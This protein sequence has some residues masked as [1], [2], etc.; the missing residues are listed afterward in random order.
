MSEQQNAA[1]VHRLYEELNKD[2]LD[3][4]EEVIAENFVAHGETMGLDPNSKDRREAMKKGIKWAKQIFPD[5]I[6]TINETI[7]SGDRVVCRLTW[8][9]TQKDA[10]MGVQPSGEAITWTAIAINRIENGQIA[11][12]WFNSDELGM[13][14]QMG[15]IPKMGP[16]PA[17]EVSEEAEAAKALAQRYID[18]VN[19]KEE[20][21]LRATFADDF[22]DK[23]AVQMSGLA[24]GVEGLLQAHRMLDTAFPD[25]HFQ[26]EDA[27]VEGDQLAIRIT[28]SGT[29]R[30]ELFG[31]PATNKRI[32]WSGHRI[33]TIR[34]GRFTEGTNELDQVGIMT[35]LGVMPPMVMPGAPADPAADKAAVARLY[36]GISAG[37][38][39]I[40][41]EIMDPLAVIHG[42]S[43]APLTRG[44][45]AYK[46]TFA[47]IRAAFPDLKVTIE[48]LVAEDDRVVS[49]LR[50]TGTHTETFMGFIQPT[51]K[52]MSWGEIVT[53]RFEN[54]KIVERWY[55]TDVLG[56]FRQLGLVPE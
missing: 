41:D 40:I 29:Q 37:N 18:G 19:N 21:E 56:I 31:I 26:I 23:N 11:E 53:D 30:G 25:I 9:G 4:V 7:A 44:S 12:R 54:G 13:M 43:M 32:S 49:R 1:I 15:L 34:D 6:V 8:K 42:D 28:A 5:L 50:W 22:L 35:Q 16:P 48:N 55:N 17:K 51:N 2:N 27:V 47:P 46:A 24:E 10:F 20:S 33:L 52:V 38:M 36:E 45:E 3:V 14:Q 39:N